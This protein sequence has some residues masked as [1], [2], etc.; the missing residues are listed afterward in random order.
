MLF[1]SGLGLIII[2]DEVAHFFGFRVEIL[3]V[4]SII[5]VFVM[6][7]GINYQEF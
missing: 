3:E 2:T 5:M 4:K 6:M 7:V 1:G